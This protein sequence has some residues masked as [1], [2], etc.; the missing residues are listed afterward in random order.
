MSTR[1]TEKIEVADIFREHI[2]DYLKKY[3]LS[4][5]QK[6]VVEDIVNCRTAYFGGHIE[7]CDDCGYERHSYNSCRNRHCPKC[8]TMTKE[9]WLEAR[10]A[11][12]LPVL[13]FHNVFTL[14]HDLN[15]VILWNK[16]LMLNLLFK[17][18]SETLQEF[19]AN[20]ENGLGG[21]IGFISILHTW[22][23]KLLDHFHL[24]CLIPGGALL[25]DENQ[26][27]SSQNNF[28]FPVKALSKVF[29]GKFISHFE[30][31]Y[32]NAKLVF[33]GVDKSIGTPDGFKQLINQLWSKD[34]VVYIKKPIKNPVRVLEYLGRYTH[35]VA[36][37]NHRILALENGKVTFKFN[38]RKTRKMEKTTID[39]VEF[40]RRFLLHILPKG[41]MRIRNYGFLANN[42][43]KKLIGIC[44]KSLGLT[45]ELPE[46]IERTIQ[47]MM[48]QLTGIDI[49]RCP[50]CKKGVLTVVAKIQ[51][52]RTPFLNLKE[53]T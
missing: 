9:K 25:L 37:S 17:S 53:F 6:K 31:A 43:K 39:A 49:N 48:L 38:N 42:C 5:D 47:E 20:S 35:R 1:A 8:Q 24:H 11:E 50:S 27:K 45:E 32:N 40:I 22:D 34:W 52:H 41:F 29:R 15:Y 10:K 18:V 51:E 14:P 2:D 21:K 30:K 7:K 13:Y 12:L 28:L 46:K 36:I 26:W 16:R 33:P 4:I 19:G 23:Q 44:R 3:K